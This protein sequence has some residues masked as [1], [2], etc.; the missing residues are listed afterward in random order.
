[1]AP[2]LHIFNAH[3][4]SENSANITFDVRDMGT[5][6]NL[7]IGVLIDKSK[8]PSLENYSYIFNSPCKEAD[9]YTFQIT[10]I[11]S[12]TGYY[13]VA[14]AQVEDRNEIIYSNVISFTT[15]ATLQIET[16]DIKNLSTQSA[17]IGCELSSIG[18]FSSV[19][20]GIVL[21]DNSDPTLN[22][23]LIEKSEINTSTGS[24]NFLFD[25]LSPNTT[26]FARAFA[27]D[28]N[29]EF[30]SSKV[31]YGQSIE[32]TTQSTDSAEIKLLKITEYGLDFV[33]V[34]YEL[35]S[36]G[37]NDGWVSLG[38][39]IDTINNPS[40]NISLDMSAA[41]SKDPEILEETFYNLSSDTEY[42]VRAYVM[43]EYN[44]VTLY[45]NEISFMT[46]QQ[47]P[48]DVYFADEGWK[49]ITPNKIE[50][51]IELISL[52]SNEYA[53]IGVIL[54]QPKDQWCELSELTIQSYDYIYTIEN[55]TEGVYTAIFDS[56]Q[57]GTNYCGLMFAIGN[58]T[59]NV[60][61]NGYFGF[62][63]KS[64]K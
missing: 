62:D 28:A 13:A 21:G 46:L 50:I 55:A 1:M 59:T 11:E 17:E 10:N 19:V 39:V 41:M 32:F 40:V 64:N 15:L 61:Y 27:Y 4:I 16:L 37:N 33:T 8:Q 49:E 14:Y 47:N 5:S 60:V 30:V 63:T 23:C 53:T 36:A 3:S 6:K 24:F 56:L 25:K 43:D 42:F 26:Y 54:Q 20:V 34:H 31:E 29:S 35:V 48:V 9:R 52:G 45:S 7:T 38:I 44:N 12:N 18:E 22:H 2:S 51:Y 57:S 58:N